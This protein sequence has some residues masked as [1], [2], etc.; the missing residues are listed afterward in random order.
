MSTLS[1][2]SE[3]GITS[4]VIDLDEVL[5]S[6]LRALNTPALTWSLR[7]VVDEATHPRM[8][9]GNCSNARRQH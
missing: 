7:F 4:E 1:A 2:D 3:L 5:L 9:V 6:D 8:A